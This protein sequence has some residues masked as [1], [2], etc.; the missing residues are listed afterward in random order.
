MLLRTRGSRGAD[1]DHARAARGVVEVRTAIAQEGF[2]EAGR[3]LLELARE[4]FGS[5]EQF[6]E[7]LAAVEE[8]GIEFA[9]PTRTLHIEALVP[10]AAEVAAGGGATGGL[11][12]E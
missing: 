6:Q 4:R 12:R 10:G 8:Q 9:F 2:A 3:R 11:T 7:I 1:R 5:T